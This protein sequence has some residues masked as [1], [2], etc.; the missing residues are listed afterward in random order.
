DVDMNRA[1]DVRPVFRK[2]GLIAEKTGCAIV[3]IG[4]LNKSC[5]TQSTYRGLGSIY[6]MAA[7]R[8]FILMGK[9]R[10]ETITRVLI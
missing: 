10:K 5:G 1:N 2:L 6:I 4:H 8:S 7:V 9:V 3:L